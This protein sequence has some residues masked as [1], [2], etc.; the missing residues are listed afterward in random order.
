MK[1][2]RI[3]VIPLL[4]VLFSMI[5]MLPTSAAELSDISED[6]W[7]YD[8][9]MNSLEHG[10]IDGY[11]DG[12]FR[13]NQ[14]VT[15][16]EF[17]K[18]A[19][20]AAGLK[21]PEEKNN[22]HWASPYASAIRYFG[23]GNAVTIHSQLDN[24]IARKD[25]IRSLMIAFGVKETVNSKYYSYIPFSDMPSRNIWEL[26]GHIMNAYH[27]GIVNGWNGM[28]FPDDTITRA[29]A[30][31]IIERAL[32]VEDWTIPEPDIL[33]KLNIRYIGKYATTFKDSICSAVSKFP[34]YIIDG[35]IEKGGTVIITDE[36]PTKY[37]NGNFKS[38][39]SGMYMPGTNDVIG[40]TYGNAQTLLFDVTGTLVHEFG[41]YV[42]HEVLS[43]EDREEINNIFKDG[44]EP[45]EL[46]K[47][48]YS[49]YCET[50]AGEFFA[51]LV[52][53]VLS[54]KMF[55]GE[56]EIPRSQA[57]AEKYFTKQ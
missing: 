43:N 20:T 12:T 22:K 56:G 51:E 15:Y 53:Y 13:P 10:Y 26:D 21:I 5:L 33:N 6:A 24:K 4:M 49:D 19:A 36:N 38:E 29:E 11:E 50:N 48:L 25:A 37:Y 57:I 28:I 35:F 40:F 23:D 32:A 14:H 45:K 8:V 17:Y 31:A 42:Y 1:K 47:I 52:S 34:Q 16:G 41:H 18:M 55:A 44:K 30:V 2:K 46:T 27:L 7:Y 39:V 54:N 9:V 3:I